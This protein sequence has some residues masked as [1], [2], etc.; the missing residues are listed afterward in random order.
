[1]GRVPDLARRANRTVDIFIRMSYNT[2][3]HLQWRTEALLCELALSL[4]HTWHILNRTDITG[5]II[6]NDLHTL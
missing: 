3:M 2:H 5:D 1:M 6:T 4:K